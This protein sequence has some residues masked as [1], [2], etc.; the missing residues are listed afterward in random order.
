MSKSVEPRP[1]HPPG[2]KFDNL[3]DQAVLRLYEN[4]RHQIAAAKALGSRYRLLGSSAKDR[5]EQL[6]L[7]LTRRELKFK[8]IDW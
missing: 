4:I 7:E 2:G 3:S 5:A 6:R 8:T 1:L